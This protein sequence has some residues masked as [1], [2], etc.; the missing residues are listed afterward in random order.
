MRDLKF[1]FLLFLLYMLAVNRSCFFIRMRVCLF[2]RRC[3]Q[4]ASVQLTVDEK[5]VVKC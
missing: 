1:F 5:S 4:T 3:G 2:S